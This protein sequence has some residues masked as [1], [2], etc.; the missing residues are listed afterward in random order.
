MIRGR[1]SGF[2][3]IFHGVDLIEI[4]RI[5]RALKRWGEKFLSRIYRE[6][7]VG[8]VEELAARFAAK[9]AT[10]KALGMRVPFRDIEVRND[11][12]GKPFIMLHG[13]ALRRAKELGIRRWEISLSH[14]RELAIASVI[15]VGDEA[16]NI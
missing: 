16:H 3:M 4:G 1:F 12:R 10:I 8:R 6:E 13:K 9:E 5:E 15:G 2:K 7:E 14:S 11:R